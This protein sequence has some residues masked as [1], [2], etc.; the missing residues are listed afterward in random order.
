[1]G[2]A[3]EE[4]PWK[5]I[6]WLDQVQPAFM[7]EDRLFPSFG[8]SLLLDQLHGDDQDSVKRSTLE[9]VSKAL[10][11]ESAHTLRAIDASIDKTAESLESQMSEREDALDA[12]F[13]GLRDMED[14]ARPRPQKLLEE[15][16]ALLRLQLKLNNE[17]MKSLADEPED[18]KEDIQEMMSAQ[19][20]AIHRRYALDWRHPEPPWRAI[21]PAKSAADRLG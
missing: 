20:T 5:L 21:A 12:Y 7:T 16:N 4:G 8:L 10:E 18:V 9:V 15:I 14:A 17:Q 11:A 2:L 6:A 3:D 1:M 19:M 13:Q